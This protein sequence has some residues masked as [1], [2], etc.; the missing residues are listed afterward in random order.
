MASHLNLAARQ[1]AALESDDY[2]ALPAIAVVRGFIRAYAK[3]LKVDPVPLLAN[4]PANPAA[5]LREPLRHRTL[6]NAQFSDT[7]MRDSGYRKSG[8]RWYFAVLLAV[9]VIG[10]VALA[11]HFSVLP[12]DLQ[13]IALKMM[14]Q[15][16]FLSTDVA[17]PLAENRSAPLT[18]QPTGMASSGN[19]TRPEDAEKDKA[20]LVPSAQMVSPQTNA[21]TAQ[22][23]VALPAAPAAAD[24]TLA[25]NAAAT[26]AKPL[27]DADASNR[28]ILNLHDDSWIEIRGAHNTVA[29]KLYHAGTTAAFTITEPVQLIVGNAAGVDATLRG[30]PLVLQSST[31]NNVARLNL[32]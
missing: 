2:T 26:L 25:L 32:K 5:S 1:I 13:S 27:L 17:A 11:R 10:A 4:M 15:F 28:L 12:D 20:I 16:G 29:S 6:A 19:E 23:T 22:N 31:K 21:E 14:P 9:A 7:R 18:N 3:L 8:S 24:T 30:A